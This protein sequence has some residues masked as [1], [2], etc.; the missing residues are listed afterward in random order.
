MKS[1]SYW[2]LKSIHGGTVCLVARRMWVQF[3]PTRSLCVLNSVQHMWI[4]TH[5]PHISV[6]PKWYLIPPS[7][8]FCLFVFD[9][10]SAIPS[11][12]YR[13]R[14]NCHSNPHPSSTSSLCPHLSFLPCRVSLYYLSQGQNQPVDH[15]LLSQILP[16]EVAAGGL[17]MMAKRH[18]LMQE[19]EREL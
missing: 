10:A 14:W 15:S 9:L 19:R 16:T 18:E 8:H 2:L 3:P 13:K 11:L 7:L 12:L 17:I 5:I 4:H 1:D 6:S